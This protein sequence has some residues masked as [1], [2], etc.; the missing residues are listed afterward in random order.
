M[1]RDPIVGILQSGL[2]RLKQQNEMASLRSLAS[3]LRLSGSYLSKVFRGERKL[4][5]KLVAPLG[6][7]LRLDHHE[8]REIQRH[9][10]AELEEQKMSKLTGVRTVQHKNSKITAEYEA[11]GAKDFWLLEEWFH[12]PLLNLITVENLDSDVA[13]LASRLSVTKEKIESSL[14]RMIQDGYVTREKNG[15]LK[16][17]HMKVRFPTQRSDLRI[18]TYHKKA[19]EKALRTLDRIPSEVD[20]KERLISG[21]A[22][23]ANPEKIPQAKVILE[24]AMFQAA[25]LLSEGA[26]S[27]VFQ[28]N[29]QLFKLTK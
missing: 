13:S 6:K 27:E 21:M 7:V 16:R 17:T 14:Q 15:D 5:P 8:I 24:E 29:V 9:I 10:L 26:C 20:F 4:S 25:E 23:A 11:L 19:I 28:L 1:S 18:R 3:S 2:K 22:F 12:L